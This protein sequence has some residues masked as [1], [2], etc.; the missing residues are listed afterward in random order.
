MPECL[1]WKL[2]GHRNHN[3]CFHYSTDMSE[4][5]SRKF[6][7]LLGYGVVSPGR[8]GGNLAKTILASLLLNECVVSWPVAAK[9]QK[10]SIMKTSKIKKSHLII[11]NGIY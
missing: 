2:R 10:F 9:V 4:E 5:S 3:I 8:C 11:F 6:F 1:I 7:A